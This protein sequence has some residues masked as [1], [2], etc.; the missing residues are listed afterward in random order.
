MTP[1]V[2][3]EGAFVQVLFPTSKK[4]REP[5]LL[6]VCYCL[7][8]RP[9]LSLI[10]Y[11]TSQPWPRGTPLPFGV[12]LF[13]QEEAAVLKQRAFKLHQELLQLAIELE[14]RHRLSIERLGF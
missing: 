4:P 14:K 10:A 1:A 7:A 12:L 2:I 8:V 13:T 11:T 6:H 3:A 9:P 5:G